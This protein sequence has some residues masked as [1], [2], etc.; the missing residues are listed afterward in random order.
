MEGFGRWV[1]ARLHEMVAPGGVGE[2][3]YNWWMKNVHLFPYTWQEC[4]AVVQHEY[5][6]IITFLKLEEHRNR[7]LPPLPENGTSPTY[8]ASLDQAMTYMVDW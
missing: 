3:N 6:R 2:E 1:E 8:Y 5:S 7:H 4:H